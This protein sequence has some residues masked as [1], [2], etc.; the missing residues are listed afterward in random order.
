MS[1]ADN[2]W[3]APWV[4]TVIGQIKEGENPYSVLLRKLPSHPPPPLPASRT[5]PTFFGL[6]PGSDGFAD[7]AFSSWDA[8][9]I[10][11]GVFYPATGSAFR[12]QLWVLMGVFIV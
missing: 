7:S 3:I 12:I 9:A 6:G 10:L 11:K 8:T 4:T 1:A 2:S 5:Q